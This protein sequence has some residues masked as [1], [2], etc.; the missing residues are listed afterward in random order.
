MWA[1]PDHAL[2]GDVP[3]A[4][5]KADRIKARTV[6]KSMPPPASPMPKPTD[7]ELFARSDWHAGGS[8]DCLTRDGG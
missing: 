8:P 2:D 4:K 1:C 6:D 3:G 7:R 5:A